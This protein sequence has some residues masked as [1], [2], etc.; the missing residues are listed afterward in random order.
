MNDGAVLIG[1]I[2]TI[3]I[4]G[5]AGGTTLIVFIC[6]KW[7][8]YVKRRHIMRSVLPSRQPTRRRRR[9][10]VQQASNQLH[11]GDVYSLLNF[12]IKPNKAYYITKINK[13]PNY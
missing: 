1:F 10:R 4:V 11:A 9:V 7:R 3:V 8:D 13:Q 2:I 6:I 12:T 5:V